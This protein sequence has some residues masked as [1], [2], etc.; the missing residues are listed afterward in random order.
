MMCW[1]MFI[2]SD[3][4]CL[5]RMLMVGEVVLCLGTRV[6]ENSVLDV[7]FGCDVRLNLFK[8]KQRA[9]L[10]YGI[11]EAVETGVTTS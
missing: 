10:R 2:D 3:V 9:L 1:C 7:Q 11:V 8:T 6:S 4:G 5:C